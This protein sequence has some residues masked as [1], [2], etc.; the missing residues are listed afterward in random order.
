MEPED[1][2]RLDA[3]TVV[4]WSPGIGEAGREEVLASLGRLELRAAREGRVV[5]VE[6]EGALLPSTT[7]I[8]AAGELREKLMGVGK[9]E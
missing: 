6:D 5:F 2:R 9:E 4:V 7:V 8:G 1:L 3:D